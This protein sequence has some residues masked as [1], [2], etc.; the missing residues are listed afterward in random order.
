[1][2][3]RLWHNPTQIIARCHGFIVNGYHETVVSSNLARLNHFAAIRHR[4]AHA[5]SHARAQFDHATM[6]LAAKRYK[7]GRPGKFLRDW[8][9]PSRR[10]LEGIADE[11]KHLA[12]QITP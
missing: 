1:M 2:Q 6:N 12:N 7:G 4:I 9:S 8:E 3:Y 5:Q 11:L 10:W